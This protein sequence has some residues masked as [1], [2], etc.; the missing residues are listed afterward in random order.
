MIDIKQADRF[1]LL[2]FYGL[3]LDYCIN[4]IICFNALTFQYHAVLSI[5]HL[6]NKDD[7]IHISKAL[8]TYGQTKFNID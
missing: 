8:Q 2:Y 5:L 7:N 3:S 1:Y 6:I 4:P